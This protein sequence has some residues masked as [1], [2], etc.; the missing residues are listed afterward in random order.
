MWNCNDH[1]QQYRVPSYARN[2]VVADGTSSPF[3]SRDSLKA[4]ALLYHSPI[5]C[6]RQENRQP[7]I[8]SDISTA[9]VRQGMTSGVKIPAL[10]AAGSQSDSQGLTDQ[11]P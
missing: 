10:S 1:V 4:D 11:E 7:M 2:E 6:Y 5:F 9:E 8:D 3:V